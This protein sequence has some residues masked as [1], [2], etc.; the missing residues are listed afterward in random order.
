[1]Q[2]ST[3]LV[4]D[5]GRPTYSG[6][7][8][9]GMCWNWIKMIR[10][11]WWCESVVGGSDGS[12]GKGGADVTAHPLGQPSQST[13]T[14]STTTTTA[15]AAAHICAASCITSCCLYKAS[16]VILMLFKTLMVF[17]TNTYSV[18]QLPQQLVIVQLLCKTCHFFPNCEQNYCQYSLC[19]STEQ[20]N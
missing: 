18:Q 3:Q 1:M 7:L 17:A 4:L 16:T 10:D 12:N 15:A 9:P 2:Q 5:R 13:R 19:L 20:C 11:F 8:V 6:T 14:L